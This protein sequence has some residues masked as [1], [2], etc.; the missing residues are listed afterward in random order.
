MLASLGRRAA[1]A[2]I[3]GMPFSGFLAWCV[4]RAVYFV[5]LP[6]V[7]R[8]LRVAVDWNLELLFPR[9]I[10]QIQTTKTDHLRL[11]HYEPGELIISKHEIGRE[12]FIMKR[13]EV[14]VFQPA[15]NGS[16]ETIVATLGEGEVF[17]EKALLD[18]LPR[19]ASV[20]ART[21]VD[22]LTMSRD[23][24]V[25][26]VDKFPPL[27]EYFEKL[28]KERYPDEWPDAESLVEHIAKPVAFPQ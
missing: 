28:M 21:A 20:R 26:I 24:F 7:V 12:V 17:G 16:A 11:D 6:G 25:A 15:E 13:G 5:K 4:W 19:G 9:D 8:R 23:D 27:D 3:M 2:D 22:V 10:T 1:V 18:D 14:E